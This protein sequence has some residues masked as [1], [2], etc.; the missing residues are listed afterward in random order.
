[1]TVRRK[2]PLQGSRRLA[3]AGG[4]RT[5]RTH[6]AGTPGELWPRSSFLKPAPAAAP[7]EVPAGHSAGE[8]LKA[9]PHTARLHRAQTGEEPRLKPSGCA[10]SPRRGQGGPGLLHNPST[11]LEELGLPLKQPPPP[12]SF[13]A[14]TSTPCPFTLRQQDK[15][16]K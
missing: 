6:R 16:I 7:G 13:P 15:K 9:R 2:L 5:P 12:P 8:E 14:G 4:T 1:M 11:G 10:A 3:E